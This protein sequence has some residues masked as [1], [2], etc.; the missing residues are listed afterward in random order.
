CAALPPRPRSIMGAAV[1]LA[2]V[3]A[4]SGRGAPRG[5]LQW[6]VEDQGIVYCLTGQS[7]H[8]VDADNR[9]ITAVALPPEIEGV[10]PL[11]IGIFD[12]LLWIATDSALANADA[13][14]LDW[15]VYRGAEGAPLPGYA[16][17][18]FENGALWVAG[19]H[20]LGRFD[21][22]AEQ[23]TVY[24]VSGDTITDLALF[25][26]HLWLAC[27]G[28]VARFEPE[29]ETTRLFRCGSEIPV[30]EVAWLHTVGDELWGFGEAGVARYLPSTESWQAVACP[31]RNPAQVLVQGSLVWFLGSEGVNAYDA[32]SR[33]CR[34]PS[35]SDRVAGT[36]LDGALHEGNLY[37]ATD[38]ILAVFAPGGNPAELKG[39]LRFPGEVDGLDRM[40]LRRIAGTGTRLVGS[41]EGFIAAYAADEGQWWVR[42]TLSEPQAAGRGSVVRMGDGLEIGLWSPP[43]AVTGTYT[44]LFQGLRE[45][46]EWESSDRHRIR[47]SSRTGAASAFFDN[48][49][50]LLGDRWGAQWKGPPDGTLREAAVGWGTADVELMDLVGRPGYRG[51]RLWGEGGERSPHRGMRPVEG[52]LWAG[53]RTTRHAEE[54]FAG[55]ADA[56]R[57]AHGSV[58]IGSVKLFLDDQLLA[59]GSFTLDHSSGSFFLS[60]AERDLVT[61]D[62]TVRVSYDYWLAEESARPVIASPRLLVNGGD[63]WTGSAG[64]LFEREDGQVRSLVSGALRYRSLPDAVRR[65]A[66]EGE[67]LGDPDQ[68]GLGTRGLVTV[69]ARGLQ[70]QVKGLSLPADM[71]TE[72]RTETEYGPLERELA[73]SG[74]LDPLRELPFSWRS[75]WRRAGQSDGF[76]GGG[77]LVWNRAGLPALSLDM[78][79]REWESDTLH[80]SWRKVELGGDYEPGAVPGFEELR[81][82]VLARQSVDERGSLAKRYRSGLGRVHLRPAGALDVALLA[83]GHQADDVSDGRTSRLSGRA[84]GL[85]TATST[86]VAG[87]NLY[88]RGEGDASADYAD[89]TET[90]AT[91]DVS[92]DRSALASAVFRPGRAPLEIEGSFSRSL[93]DLLDDVD[94]DHGLVGLLG[95]VGDSADVQ[96]QRS[97][98]VGGGPLVFLPS[99]STLRLRATRTS[100][101]SADST[102]A[103]SS[104]VQRTCLLSLDMR[105]LTA[106]RWLL[107]GTG[108]ASKGDGGDNETWTIYT[109]WERRWNPLLLSRVAFNGT[110]SSGSTETWNW[111]PSAYVQA[112]PDRRGLEVRGEIGGGRRHAAE[113]QWFLRGGLRIELR[114]MRAFLARAE[115]R[116]EVSFRQ[117]GDVETSTVV[118]I[119]AGASL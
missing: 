119:R 29:Y 44:Y 85:L 8:R 96:Q 14:Y 99:Q 90:P 62:S 91:K 114:L 28:A 70:L 88:L 65:V 86:P 1:A 55:G 72:G 46:S 59:E 51:G 79:A 19:H 43:L 100:K 57:L 52:R 103:F 37:L 82:Q 35:W 81:A 38:R 60:F 112:G 83:W 26:G 27:R 63:L 40:P 54:F 53:S 75:A 4:A 104:T 41:G 20:S 77:R 39:D 87:L 113:T 45:R 36:T 73:T 32:E 118:T 12:G 17:M 67:I 94:T 80:T 95:L 108:T 16:G 105:P 89:S 117:S 64:A 110:L 21:Q 101:T 68:G 115:I 102:G 92:L 7:A 58:V 6:A 111:S 33:S 47:L 116:P 76:E 78:A 24:P 74:R 31:I 48:T 2:M 18:A 34:S 71:Q 3:C 107:E 22:Y 69:A 49:D 84:A 9:A 93:R 15:I 13:R 11:E 10:S 66:A 23:W 5:P 106:S 61:E 109:R 25:D 30:G 50:Q 42:E 97:T 56:Y 98:V